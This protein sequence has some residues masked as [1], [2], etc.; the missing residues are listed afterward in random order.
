MIDPEIV[1]PQVQRMLMQLAWRAAQ[2]R[3]HPT[4]EDAFDEARSIAYEAFMLACSKYEDERSSFTTF[5]HMKVW[6]ALKSAEM[7]GAKEA[8]RIPIAFSLQELAPISGPT[9]EREHDW[10]DTLECA[11]P[12]IP[13]FDLAEFTRDLGHDA[14]EIISM[15]VETPAELLDEIPVTPKQLLRVVR[16]YMCAQWGDARRVNRAINQVRAQVAWELHRP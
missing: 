2:R 14:R 7:H 1:Y 11:A 15:L 10:K 5:C 4:L 9:G 8:K 16:D 13:R 3:P 6:F 12:E